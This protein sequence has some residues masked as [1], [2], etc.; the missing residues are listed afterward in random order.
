MNSDEDRNIAFTKVL[1]T[2]QYCFNS[3]LT[4]QDP[5]DTKRSTILCDL[6]KD[7][8]AVPPDQDC[9]LSVI[10][11]EIPSTTTPFQPGDNQTFFLSTTTNKS[12]YN[13]V[14]TSPVN[15]FPDT[16]FILLKSYP[17]GMCLNSG[18]KVDIS[19]P[20][21]SLVANTMYFVASVESPISPTYYTQIDTN[22]ML[23]IPTSPY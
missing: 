12:T 16:T 2:R 1:P 13:T 23:T 20:G 5:T 17:V 8:F 22:V 19:S 9:L 11:A 18:F 4:P 10:T 14:Y 15:S 7:A 21:N 3:R 6:G